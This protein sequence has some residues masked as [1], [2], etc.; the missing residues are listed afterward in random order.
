M[1]IDVDWDLEMGQFTLEQSQEDSF[2][3][4]Y[5]GGNTGVEVEVVWLDLIQMVPWFKV[6]VGILY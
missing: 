2:W 3:R 6:K 5:E 4:V 1:E